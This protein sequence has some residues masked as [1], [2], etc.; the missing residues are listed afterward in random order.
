MTDR[1]VEPSQGY[2]G[3]GPSKYV[4]KRNRQYSSSMA[5]QLGQEISSTKFQSGNGGKLKRCYSYL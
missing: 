2:T 5:E 4:M 3:I 1:S